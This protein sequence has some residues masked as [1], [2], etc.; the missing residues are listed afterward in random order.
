MALLRKLFYRKP[1][2][3]FFEICERVYVFDCCFTTDAWKEENYKVYIG[4]IVGQL[5]DHLPDASF[6]VFNFHD[7]VAQSQMASILSEYDMTIMDYPRHF[8]G[9]PVLTLELIHHFLRSS[10]SW[11][12][13]GQN[14]VLLM[15]CE[16]GGWPVLAFM[17]SALLIYH[18]QYSGEQRT[19]DM[20]YRQ[21]PSEL[22]HLLSPL[23]PIPSQLR[24]LQYVT[25][26]NVA[27]E[28]PPLDRALT[29][30]CVI[31]RFVPNFDGQ[32]GC[33]PI[34]RIY[35][36]DP[37]LANDKT[38]KVLFSTPKKGKP[39][40]AYKQVEC[41]L[42]KIDINCHIQGDVVVECISLHDD[43]EREEMMFRVMFNTAFIR[44]NI[45][46]LN[47]DEIDMLWDAKEQFPKDF[48]VEILFSEMDAVTSIILGGMSCFEDKEGLPMEAFAQVQEIF[49]YVDWLD[50]KSDATLNVLQ[51]A[52]N[53]IQEKLNSDSPRSTGNDS[54]ET[55]PGK[56]PKKKNLLFSDDMQS[57]AS[58][59]QSQDT[60]VSKQQAKPQDIPATPQPS[61]QGDSVSQHIPQPSHSTTMGAF[62][63]VQEIFNHATSHMQ[64]PDSTVSKQEAKPSK[65]ALQPPDKHD[66]VSQKMPQP[67][68]STPM[69]AKSQ[70]IHTALQPT[71]KRDA[72]SQKIPQP[73]QSTLM[74]TKPQDIHTATKQE[75][76]PQ[77]VCS[78]I[79]QEANPQDIHAAIQAPN[80]CDSVSQ[81]RPEPSQ[82]TPMEEAKPQDNP[83]VK[84]QEAKPQDIP[85]AKKQ[86]AKPQ[87]IP[88]AKKQEAKPQ[89]IPTAKKQEAKPQDI[90]TVKKQEAKPQD[91]PT[92]LQPSDKLNSVSQ[93][94]PQ[95]SQSSPMEAFSQVQEI[96]S[97][98]ASPV[99]Y[100]DTTMSK[101]EGKPQ[102]IHA[103]EV[104]SAPVAPLTPPPPPPPPPSKSTCAKTT[105][106]SPP[107]PQLL[108]PDVLV[109]KPE[110]PSLSEETKN[111][112]SDGAQQSTTSHPAASGMPTSSTISGKV[113]P[114]APPTPRSEVSSSTRPP[115]TPSTPPPPPPTPPLKENLVDG[116][117][118]PPP[119]PPPLHSG[120]A[121][122]T[123]ISSPVPPPPT[124]PTSSAKHGAPSA[125]PPPPPIGK[126][127][128]KPGNPPPP[129]ISSPG[130]AKGRL[131]RTISSKNNN[132]KK[133]KP[134]HW[135]KLSR[136][137]QGSLWAEAQK[138]DEEAKAPE[139][140]MSELETLFS[141]AA[142]AQDKG[143]KSAA[144]GS[145][146]PKSEKVQLIDHRRA[147]N[148]EI[149]LSKVKV[150]LNEL[151]D[152]VLALE[153][154]ALDVDQVENLIK[155]CP[156]KEEM[157]LL[158]GYTG[159][160]EK[161]GK[162]EQFLLEL[163][164]V[165]RVESKLRV[166][167]FKIQFS[168]Q[169]SDLRNSLNVVN[170]AAEEIR[171]SGK[172][173][174]IMQTILSL[175]NALNQG[176]A[177]GS[178][179]GFRL[180]S[181][182]KLIETRARNNKM[183]LMH[184]LCKVLVDQLPEVLDFSKDLGNLEPASRIQLKFLAEEMQALSKGLE[185]VV[186][187]LST[188]ENDGPISEKFRKILKE[189]LRFAE[190]E[191]RTLASLY[192]TVGRNVDALI[193]Y[194][195][196][197]PAKCPFEQVVT[198]LLNFVRMFNKAHDENCKQSENEMKKA[199]ES[200]KLKMGASKE[201]ERLL[202][203]PIQSSNVK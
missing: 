105:L 11:L 123:T 149:M 66:S 99:Q 200:E 141:V 51:A 80:K 132:S 152:S 174:R 22:L 50:P 165:P 45:L 9:C 61:N 172:L 75:A 122:G 156:T 173:K 178:A 86:E 102:D 121:G 180:D 88:S 112:S 29:L 33:R 116:S 197:D 104:R 162:C 108:P 143:R 170:S 151:M 58:P 113:L 85:T 10:E 48:R 196:E 74:D 106:P 150:P 169:V 3:G 158:K 147:Y 23:N 55:S 73:S 94:L 49:N 135:L 19:L 111:Y 41:E 103:V 137:V 69:E 98:A 79:K 193:L 93:K 90:P 38:P 35:G 183:T 82:S 25:R 160:K 177:R 167:S 194:F 43:L 191:V 92:T 130:G 14:N 26:R 60:S 185:K 96:F 176:T 179:I 57:V 37:F 7:G 39:I 110:D 47:R 118:P 124:A 171:N 27:L 187:E 138:S 56:T 32:G 12:S 190:G 34:F 131:L 159:E 30:E 67:S 153:D 142:P 70:D 189:F 71:N 182:L 95:P 155:F 36:Q 126:G 81:Q 84:K 89:D 8:E 195:G 175:G 139:I 46:M 186:Q 146:A 65:T 166:F 184:Y 199:A 163:M 83:T 101:Q 40:R 13:L 6:L 64:S 120:Q 157:E 107:K 201:S 203:T 125:P 128:S 5:Q 134:L 145:V 63:Q 77:D 59:R 53:I 20:V 91:I 15:H 140:D 87:D 117:R 115:P 18:K 78:A 109:S 133:L 136:A 42:V 97:H 192:S 44:S 2:D 164:K 161:L 114:K 4:G 1:P 168:S 127:G 31:F 17:L 198:T 119:P 202:R 76:K 62:A 54:Q 68:K 16:R 24:Y 100:P 188:S 52:S 21:A 28:W 144:H 154:T 129:P 72:V 148:C 181:L